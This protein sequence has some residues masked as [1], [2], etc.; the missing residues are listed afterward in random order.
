MTSPLN[1]TDLVSQLENEEHDS[2]KTFAHANSGPAPKR[3]VP[4]SLMPA[5]ESAIQEADLL[6]MVDEAQRNVKL[7]S[8]LIGQVLGRLRGDDLQRSQYKTMIARIDGFNV[9]QEAKFALLLVISLRVLGF[10]IAVSGLE[11]EERFLERFDPNTKAAELGREMLEEHKTLF[12]QD[13]QEI[14]AKGRARTS[15]A[16]GVG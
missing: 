12:R 5:G 10:K 8:G 15:R 2:A 4:V 7:Q 11:D 1:L 13:V 16:L 9:T 3:A 6:Q 14:G